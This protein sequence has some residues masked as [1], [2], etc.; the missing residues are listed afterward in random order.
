MARFLVDFILES[1]RRQLANVDALPQLCVLGLV[2]GVITGTVIWRFAC[3]LKPG[4]CSICRRGSRKPSKDCHRE[5]AL[6]P[7]VAVTL[8]GLLLYR[9]RLRASSGS[10]M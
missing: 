8:I 5:R 6:L 10:A 2:S 3:C 4:R 7:I 1:F 9:Q